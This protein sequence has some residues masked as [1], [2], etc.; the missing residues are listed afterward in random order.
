MDRK[1]IATIFEEE[2]LK[3]ENKKRRIGVTICI[4]AVF[5]A[6]ATMLSHEAHTYETIAEAKAVD[7]WSYYQAKH[8]R[9]HEYG[10]EAELTLQLLKNEQ[11]QILAVKDY[12]KSIEEQCGDPPKK[13]CIKAIPVINRDLGAQVPIVERGQNEEAKKKGAVDILAEADNEQ[14]KVK[15]TEHQALLYDISE[16]FL[17]ISIVLCSISLLADSK[18][19]WKISFITTSIGV[20]VTFYGWMMPRL[21]QWFYP[22]WIFPKWLFP[23]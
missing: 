12:K 16:L 2:L 13:D 15:S 9:A 7:S 23:H 19:Y 10:I 22:D 1:E 11:G 4:S 8:G 18:V 21:P 20:A 3:L 17:E 5:L 14:N 6:V